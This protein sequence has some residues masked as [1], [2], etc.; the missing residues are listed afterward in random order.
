[1]VTWSSSDATVAIISNTLGTYGLAT[2]SGQGT[3][4]ITATSASITS[5][6]TLTVSQAALSS[7]AVTPSSVSNMVGSAQQF[8]AT[9]T[10]SDGSTQDVTQ[11]ATWTSS[12]PN[13]ASISSP[14]LAISMLAGTT[15]ISANTGS[16][17][18]SAFLTVYAPVPLSL[19][20]APSTATVSAGVQ[21]QLG[22]TLYF[23]DGSSQDVTSAVTW[24]SSNTAVATVGSAGLAVSLTV[25]SASI[26]ANWGA[27]LLTAS[28]SMI[29]YSANTFFVSPNGNDAWTG[30]IAAPNSNNSDGPFASVSRAQYAV[31]KAPKP[32]AVMLRNGTYYLALTRSATNSYSGTLIFTAA[33]SGTS[34]SAPVTWQ[35]YPGET[36]VISGGVPANAD[37]VSGLGLHLQWTNTGNWYQAALPSTLSSTLALQPFEYLFYNGQRRMRSRIHDNGSSGYPSIGYFMQNGQCV[38]SQSTPAGQQSPTL[39]SCNL[40][41]FLRVAN[42]IAPSSALGQG[43]PFASAIVNNVTVSKCLDR[44]VYS[45]TSGGDPI[46]AWANLNGSYSGTPAIP[47][48][49]GSN[50]YPP[51]DVELTLIDA[52]SVDVMRVSCVDTVDHVI[53]LSGSTKGGGTVASADVNYSHLG[54]TI[55]HRY[56]I[57]NTW[58]AFNAALTPTSSQ[59]GITGIWFLDR[60]AAP[61]VLNYIANQ[62][63]N[64]ATDSIVIPQ[65]GGAIPGAPATDYVGASLVSATNLNYVT[66]Q[67]ISFEVDDFYPSGTGFNND[68]NGEMSVPQAIDCENCQFVTFDAVT[69]RHTSAS[70]ILAAASTATPA[71]SANQSPS[72]VVIENS[73]L[74]DI[75]DS[76]IRVGHAVRTSDTSANVVQ[77]VLAQ[78]NLIQGY[79][80]VFPDGEGIAEANG[81]NNQYSYNTITDGY[82]AGIS[83]CQGGCGPTK[84]GAS[85]NGNNIISSYN[86]ISNLI[87]G[88]TSDGGALFYNVGNASTSGV[89]D[90]ITSNVIS[91]VTDSYII[92]NPATAGVVVSGSAYG[93]NGIYLDAQSANIDVANNVV[94]N[95]S[96]FAVDISEGLSS[97]KESQNT[98]NNNIFAFANSGMFMQPSPWPSGCP[99][100]SIK[101]V[102]VINNIF[103]F[104]RLSTSTPSFYVVNGCS[105]SCKQ[106]YNTYQNF[107]GNSYW[108]TNGQ[109]ASDSK[110]FQILTTQGLNSNNSCKTSPTTSLYFSSQTAPNWQT[111]GKGLPVSMSE[112]LP[113]NATASYQ[114]PF[115]ASGLTTDLPGAY[116]FPSG[117]APSTPF[118]PANTNLTISNAHSSLPQLGNVPA[119]FPTY[120]YG[121]PSNKF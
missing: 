23:S 113:P 58:D 91:N 95:L 81:N 85:V 117:Q 26:E 30:Q 78:N 73:S 116:V 6:T 66:F 2:S 16:V 37:P 111:G 96:G 11:S 100:S 14:G 33:D 80:R 65:L 39:A 18:G 52:W 55:G 105:D 5:S 115:T 72:C 48:N 99:A 93:G 108:R 77:G 19:V 60:R 32:A 7:I 36:P 97:S 57:E 1:V 28:S 43:C 49:N 29:V 76:A 53:F 54:P 84:S 107:Q 56:M 46:T 98:F 17:A 40:G 10:Y 4:A 110:A 68:V 31:E 20:I 50:S 71:C 22:A 70:G 69:V 9:A 118:L 61:W 90:S 74:Y 114:P 120:V 104:D 79:S 8:T 63:E 75:G 25:G 42:T 64:P 86:F 13:V 24:S 82:H 109:F 92:D 51:G 35:N 44:F 38:A 119:T 112:D 83:I 103:Y 67:G 59:Y 87:Q 106:A 21:L 34:L 12:I 94:Y 62:G 45:N 3:A 102:D 15:A 121:S 101:Q 47:C 41:T 88:V 89:G 27:N